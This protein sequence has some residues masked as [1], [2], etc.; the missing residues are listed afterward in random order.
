M[1]APLSPAFRVEWKS[2]AAL[3]SMLDDWRALAA[4]AVEPNVFY[5]PGFALAA[6]PALYADAGALTVQSRQRLVGLMPVRVERRRFGLWPALSVWVHEYGPLGV[7]LIDRDEPAA[8]LC[9]LFDHIANDTGLPGLLMMPM[10]P[11]RGPLADAVAAAV[12]RRGA[13]VAT[14]EPHRR[15][16]LAP[17]AAREH[18]LEHAVSAGRRKEMRRLRRRLADAAPVT[19]A[20]VAA[21][22]GFAP[23]LQDFLQL[24]AGGWKGRAGTAAALKPE[25][26][27]FIET[28]TTALA[29]EGKASVHRLRCGAD[30]IA[31][32]ITLRSG[33][34]A[35]WWKTA[36]SE[37]VAHAS[38]GVQLAFDLTEALLGDTRIARVDSCATADHPMIDHIWRERLALADRLI[39]LRCSAAAFRAACGIEALRRGALAAARSLRD[40]LRFR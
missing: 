38:P 3:A 26:R 40:R 33:D 37:G 24:E 14:F 12:E 10:L 4:R 2:F 39:A 22:D 25:I 7:P 28:A 29:G 9:A 19:F 5:E 20:T 13:Q 31:A 16:L 35:W 21:P 17:G 23:A 27:N 8:A 1:H 30:S 36:Y 34:T 18:Y 11:E 15:A 32:A 6:A